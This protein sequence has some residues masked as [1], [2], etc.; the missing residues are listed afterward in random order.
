[1]SEKYNSGGVDGTCSLFHHLIGICYNLKTTVLMHSKLGRNT[2]NFSI[3]NEIDW[4]MPTGL[5]TV[6]QVF[7]E[8]IL[9][10]HWSRPWCS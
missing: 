4:L 3:V 2:G 1:M 6:N 8:V 5:L 9:T 10:L 7:I